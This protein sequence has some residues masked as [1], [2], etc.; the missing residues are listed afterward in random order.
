YLRLNRQAV[1]SVSGDFGQFSNGTLQIEI[2]GAAIGEFGQMHIAGVAKL[3]GAL[4]VTLVNGFTPAAGQSF[5][6]FS[7]AGGLDETFKQL[8]LPTLPPGLQWNLNYASRALLLSVV[9]TVVAGDF[10]RDGTV[11]AADY[12]LWQKFAGQPVAPGNYADTNNDG[13]VDEDDL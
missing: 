1:L 7:A 11:D 10:N 4:Q 12:V 13:W 3:G 8:S 6:F 2:G 5:Q 9:S